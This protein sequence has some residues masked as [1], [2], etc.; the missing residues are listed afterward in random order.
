[1]IFVLVFRASTA[2]VHIIECPSD[3]W[4]RRG[5]GAHKVYR[6]HHLTPKPYECH[7][8][9]T[10]N[11]FTLLPTSPVAYSQRLKFVMNAA[12]R[13]MTSRGISTASICHRFPFFRFA[14]LPARTQ[15]P[16]A[17]VAQGYGSFLNLARVGGGCVRDS[18][19]SGN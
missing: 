4:I 10:R 17:V 9:T 14:Q 5:L 19:W 18:I 6:E 11:V 1:M 2:L 13:F 7:T 3:V 16:Q 8:D 15:H 12:K